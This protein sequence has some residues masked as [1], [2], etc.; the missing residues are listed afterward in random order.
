MSRASDIVPGDTNHRWD[1]FVRDRVAG[2]TRR[3]SVDGAGAEAFGG[4]STLNS[5]SG[6]GRF[7]AFRSDVS[8]VPA[9]PAAT[10]K[11]SS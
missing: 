7:V 3:V 2:N 11:E 4:H 8:L 6:D 5:I 10:A 9:P 1:V